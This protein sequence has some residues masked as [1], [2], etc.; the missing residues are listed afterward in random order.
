MEYLFGEELAIF[1]QKQDIPLFK[2]PS[3]KEIA[4]FIKQTE[5]ILSPEICK[6]LNIEYHQTDSLPL[7]RLQANNNK[8]YTGSLTIQQQLYV[9]QDLIN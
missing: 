4:E 1:L 8:T 3:D 7:L 5:G 2:I 6:L 9:I